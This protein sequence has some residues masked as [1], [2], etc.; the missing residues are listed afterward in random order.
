M[1]DLVRRV[2]QA[3]PLKRSRT[4][5]RGPRTEYLAVVYPAVG[6]SNPVLG[7]A[8][9][10]GRLMHDAFP[11]LPVAVAVVFAILM[12]EGFVVTTLDSSVRLCRYLLEEFWRFAFAGAPPAGRC[13]PFSAPAISS[14]ARSR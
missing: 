7:F 10:A 8:L 1:A 3:G 5:D 6:P 11:V 9:G 14:S 12:V 2:R 4:Q 13:G